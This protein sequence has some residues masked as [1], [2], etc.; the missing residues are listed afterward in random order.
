[1]VYQY[2]SLDNHKYAVMNGT[3]IRKWERQFTK[4][5]VANLVELNWIDRGPG[6]K[7]YNMTLL[8]QSWDSNS[9]MYQNGVTESFNT[10]LSNLEASYVAINT[11]MEFIDPLGNSVPLGGVYF[12]SLT[13]TIPSYS[14]AQKP[15]MLVD[16]EVIEAKSVI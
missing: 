11:A 15:M 1:M 4:G 7:S 16:I 6:I 14:T 3:Y 10:Q 13:C 12:T 8:V 9:R 2:I 5:L